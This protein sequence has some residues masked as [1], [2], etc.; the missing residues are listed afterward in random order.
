MLKK[1]PLLFIVVGTKLVSRYLNG[2]IFAWSMNKTIS[3]AGLAA[4]VL[5][6]NSCTPIRDK[7]MGMKHSDTAVPYYDAVVGDLVYND[8]DPV[9]FYGPDCQEAFDATAA[10]ESMYFYD[11]LENVV[12]KE[13]ITQLSLYARWDEAPSEYNFD[14]AWLLLNCPDYQYLVSGFIAENYGDP[15]DSFSHI[16]CQYFDTYLSSCTDQEEIYYECEG[17]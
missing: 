10:L 14:A 7:I 1:M 5:G 17:Y 8:N 4:L 2:S 16:S 12:L 13:G 6:Q 3:S 9:L 11:S 15:S